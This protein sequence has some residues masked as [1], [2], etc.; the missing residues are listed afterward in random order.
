MW[1]VIYSATLQ[2][3]IT[4]S[5]SWASKGHAHVS[6][7]YAVLVQDRKQGPTSDEKIKLKHI[8]RREA[9]NLLVHKL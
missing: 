6:K 8:N 9:Q 3:I 5:G 4:P 7:Y 2:F 1:V